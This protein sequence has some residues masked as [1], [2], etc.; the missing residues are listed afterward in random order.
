MKIRIL[1]VG[2][3][4]EKFWNDAVSEYSKR[5]SGFCNFS[6]EE[7]PDL[8][9]PDLSSKALCQI[10]IDKEGE[11]ILKRL[12]GEKY[13]A[14]CVEGKEVTSEDLCTVIENAA[15]YGGKL[16]FVIGGSL[17][18]SE[19]VKNGA[20]M[21]LSMSRMTFPHALARVILTEQIYRAYTILNNQNYHK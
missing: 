3:L 18:L 19:K 11:E 1:A 12:K 5:L 10:T 14:L 20:D 8:K 21:R 13:I 2:K 4:N 6:I 9:N 16:N 15:M 17:G 7:I